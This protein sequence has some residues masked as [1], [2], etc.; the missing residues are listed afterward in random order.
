MVGCYL[1]KGED[2]LLTELGRIEKQK[3]EIAKKER[4]IR[5]TLEQL[6]I[7]E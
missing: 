6:G 5:Q 2:A 4:L 1:L 7:K 3:E